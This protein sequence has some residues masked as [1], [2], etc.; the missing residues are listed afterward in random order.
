[1][2]LG[3]RYLDTPVDAASLSLLVELHPQ[4]AVS[5]ARRVI[6]KCRTPDEQG[7]LL[8]VISLVR[9]PDDI[10]RIEAYLTSDSSEVRAAAAESLGYIHHPTYRFRDHP[11]SWGNYARL[12]TVPPIDVSYLI[13]HGFPEH[14][15]DF[16]AQEK[17]RQRKI[18]AKLRDRLEAGA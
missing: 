14:E 13:N 2:E 11:F 5:I 15:A 12:N 1:L 17:V 6:S 9:D 8:R 18:P 3:I 4:E 7:M 10:R 16:P